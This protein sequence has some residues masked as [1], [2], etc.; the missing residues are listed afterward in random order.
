[1]TTSKARAIFGVSALCALLSVTE[2]TPAANDADPAHTDGD[3][4]TVVVDNEQVR[5]L[6]YHDVPGAKTHPHHHP[7]FV[8]IALS[9]FRRKLTFPDGSTKVREFAAGEAAYMPAQTHTGENIGDTATDSLLVEL[10][11]QK[12]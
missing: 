2:Q 9:P 8:M 4:Y 3:K 6:R 5:V 10:K 7:S 11:T 1:M 12:N